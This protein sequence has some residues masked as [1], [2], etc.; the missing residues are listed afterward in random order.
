MDKNELKKW[1]WGDRRDG[2]L[3][4]KHVDS[5]HVFLPLMY[6]GRTNNEAFIS[7]RIDLTAVNEYLAKKNAESDD[8]FKYTLFHV[9]VAAMLKVG[10]LKPKLNRFICRKKLY[11]R[12]TLSAAFVVKKHFDEESAEGLAFLY[13][14][15]N[16]NI[17]TL[18]EKLRN[19]IYPVKRGEG[20]STSDAMDTLVKLPAPILKAVGFGFRQLGESGLIPHSLIESDPAYSSV[21]L[22]NLGSIKLKS[23]YHH[24][25][26]W[27][28]N[29]LFV[30]V[31]E[32]KV[33]PFFNED[34]TFEMKDSVDIGLTIDERIAD[35]YYY[36]QCVKLLQK[37]LANPELLDDTLDTPVEI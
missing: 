35:G 36:S 16:D 1:H 4:T 7:E 17:D 21:F 20:D 3:L 32:R 19:Q 30:V 27:G 26:N 37:L 15:D 31:G 9:I 11:Q 13:A 6:V 23:G 10:T 5:M 8:E 2:V 24:L 12:R 28:T 34:G 22:T 29:S 33:R 18:H 25:T 14:D